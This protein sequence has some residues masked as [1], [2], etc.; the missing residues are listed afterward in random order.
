MGRGALG[1]APRVVIGR[2]PLR[3]SF[4][5][6]AFLSTSSPHGGWR[7]ILLIDLVLIAGAALVI[8]LIPVRRDN[9]PERRTPQ[10]ASEEVRALAERACFD[11]H[12]DRTRWPWYS[13]VAP[14]SWVLWYD[15]TQGREK[16]NFSDW[17]RHAH[18]ETV[19]PNDPFPPK[20][21]SERIA[22]EIRSGAMPPGT[23]LLMHPD[24]RLSDAEREFLIEGLVQTVQQ[25]QDPPQP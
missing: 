2:G 12:S 24:A 14:V 5:T 17:D 11:C 15:V 22:Q 13:R 19:D 25:S 20:T 3:V 1:R 16:L 4:V 10:W 18:A 21:L 6:E 23:Y 9:P 8:Q 7:R